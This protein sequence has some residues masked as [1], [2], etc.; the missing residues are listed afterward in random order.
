MRADC[1]VD[2]LCDGMHGSVEA[3]ML[4]MLWPVLRKVLIGV[5]DGVDLTMMSSG[6]AE[7][8]QLV[9]LIAG[10]AS[11]V[12]VMLSLSLTRSW[13]RAASLFSAGAC[14]VKKEVEQ[15]R[16]EELEWKSWNG[17]VGREVATQVSRS[18]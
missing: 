4:G 16:I 9:E 12:A 11:F 17:R 1:V 13:P 5:N 10:I 2:S 15:N 18:V 14:P 3:S 7:N 6:C 8:A